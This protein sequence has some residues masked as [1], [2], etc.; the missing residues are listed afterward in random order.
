[1]FLKT[2]LNFRKW[3][4]CGILNP[5][6][7]SWLY[8]RA[9][10]QRYEK[11]EEPEI[12]VEICTETRK[13]ATEWCRLAGTAKEEMFKESEAPKEFCD[14]H[15]DPDPVVD[16]WVCL[17]TKK[18]PRASC[19]MTGYVEMK[20]SEAPKEFCKVHKLPKR[21]RNPY[22]HHDGLGL[23]LDFLENAY[24]KNKQAETE[25]RIMNYLAFL[26]GEGVD[27]AAFF[28]NLHTNT[29]FHKHLNWKTPFIKVET[30]TGNKADHSKENPRYYELVDRFAEMLSIAKIKPQ[31]IAEMD[32]YTTWAYEKEN[33]V[34]GV[35]NF[36]HEKA[37]PYQKKHVRK[38][39][40]IFLKYFKIEDIH[41]IAVN[42][43]AHGGQDKMGH[44]IANYHKA[45]WE[46]C[47]DLGLPLT[48][49]WADISES[50]FTRSQLT[51]HGWNNECLKCGQRWTERIEDLPSA[52]CP[53]PECRQI[54]Y[55]KENKKFMINRSYDCP[56][57]HTYLWDNI[58]S[59]GRDCCAIGHGVSIF[60]DLER[61]H[62]S[63]EHWLG[64]GNP[65]TKRTEDAS[66]NPDC[67]GHVMGH[68]FPWRLGDREQIKEMLIYAWTKAKNSRVKKSFI[69]GI[70]PMEQF[71][72]LEGGGVKS[73]YSV[74][75]I[76]KD[77]FTAVGE[78]YRA[79]FGQK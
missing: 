15:E 67:R 19:R 34:N 47:R 38:L 9:D 21:W 32:R 52:R 78:A 18:K 37:R 77:R 73:F 36:W 72:F 76:D 40:E 25:Q 44:T 42:E 33:N 24:P 71:I 55:D 5:A 22:F 46:F 1:M 26:S 49:F 8:K 23:F 58:E 16:V 13:R 20:K 35:P 10:C 17:V 53:N 60:G 11:P 68:G 30:P 79:V 54:G 51:W 57:C 70:Y 4:F 41:V 66:N 45:I 29:K 74:S 50:E 62:F 56:K 12:P 43:A 28:T 39:I 65:R 64:S 48:N 59:Y 75:R 27:I 14:Q 3:F 2:F 7:G 61:G 31:M 69:W 63:F 6:K